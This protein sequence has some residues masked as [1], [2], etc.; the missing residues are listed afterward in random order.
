M[1][2]TFQKNTLLIILGFSL[3]LLIGCEEDKATEVDEEIESTNSIYASLIDNWDLYELS[4]D[5]LLVRSNVAGRIKF[6]LGR[7]GESYPVLTEEYALSITTNRIDLQGEIFC[8]DSTGIETINMIDNQL[9][10]IS[11]EED[12]VYHYDYYRNTDTGALWLRADDTPSS[13]FAI[14]PTEHDSLEVI[15]GEDTLYYPV[16]IDEYMLFFKHGAGP[17]LDLIQPENNSQADDLEVTFKW[18]NTGA[19]EYKFQLRNDED[20]ADSTGFIYNEI[21]TDNEFDVPTQLLNFQTYY[22][23][24][25]ADNSDWSE[26]WNF[27]TYNV[28]LLSSP[29]NTQRVCRKPKLIWEAYEDATSYTL[30]IADK[31]SF[32]DILIEE[33]LTETEYDCAETLND[34]AKYYWR[35][36]ADNSNGFWSETRY[37]IIDKAVALITPGSD[38]TEIA[39]PV[40]FEWEELDNFNDY[41]LKVGTEVLN[42]TLLNIVLEEIVYTNSYTDSLILEH[43]QDYYWQ[44]NSDVATKWSVIKHF[45]T[46][47]I[48]LLTAP[49]DNTEDLGVIIEFEWEE[50]AGT[51]EYVFQLATDEV[52]DSTSIIIDTTDITETTY[53]PAIDLTP[54]TEY[55]WRVGHNSSAW[56]ETWSFETNSLDIYDGYAIYP[57]FSDSIYISSVDQLP[58][59]EWSSIPETDFYRIQ[60]ATDEN[61]SNM[62]I[63]HV[64][65]D[66]SYQLDADDDGLLALD[67]EYFWRVRSDKTEWSDP[68]AFTTKHG[69]P[70]DIETN[71]NTETPNKIDLEWLCSNSEG[72][73]AHLLE[74]SEDQTNWEEI[75]SI[76]LELKKYSDLGLS[77]NTTY[78]YRIKSENQ[79]G[80]SAPSDVVSVTTGSF[81]LTNDPE[82]VPVSAGVFDMGSNSEPDELPIREIILTNDFQV[83]KYEVTNAEYCEL[84]NWALGQGLVEEVLEGNLNYTDNS[85][86]YSTILKDPEESDLEIEYLPNEYKFAV[87]NDKE[88][89]PITSIT[90]YGAAIYTNWLSQAKNKTELYDA[91]FNC[92]V[93]DENGYR[94]LTEAEWEYCAKDAG[95]GNYTYSGSNT[96]D[97]VAWYFGNA[98]EIMAVGQKNANGIDTYDMSGNL[99]EWCN[100][101]YGEYDAGQ[102]ENPTGPASGMRR[103]IRGGSW[104]FEATALRNSNRSRCKPDLAYGRTNTS[105]GF[106][107]MLLP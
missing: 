62:L 21:V 58:K 106:R 35:V 19:E 60:L 40:E 53:I 57:E 61:F 28:V 31:A 83:G 80:N 11:T 82:L 26:I 15:A 34:G 39:V 56:S 46:N 69:I 100:D 76:D 43:N 48:V 47:D 1:K 67:T 7:D 89:H 16:N 9:F 72:T 74:R 85:V 99:W 29:Q 23:R 12:T 96:V 38:A 51:D 3:L 87:T 33:N 59:L 86:D 93:Y 65:T 14:D 78:Y 92:T 18:E 79:T 94:L 6:D 54:S 13:F 17:I 81:T 8:S 41:T 75:A 44:V 104:E 98:T 73:T 95:N 36:K 24:I 88:D 91:S 5:T 22:W 55:F 45:K 101:Y 97:E 37:F 107:I 66:D 50:F 32:D 42:D 102:T 64:E 63:N 30:E 2:K 77:E 27:G 20:F 71:L 70:H 49:E 68:W 103:V 4:D 25:K 84:L 105:I 10:T 90:W 52:F